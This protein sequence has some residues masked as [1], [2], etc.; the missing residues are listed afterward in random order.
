M[1]R[2]CGV[3]GE[4]AKSDITSVSASPPEKVTVAGIGALG[5]LGTSRLD[6]LRIRLDLAAC[7]STEG[8]RD[9]PAL[10]G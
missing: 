4:E 5:V 8:F 7:L 10:A 9:R 1:E 2:E 6:S 3:A